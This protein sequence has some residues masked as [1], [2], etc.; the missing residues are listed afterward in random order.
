M[1]YKEENQQIKLDPILIANL[2]GY[3]NKFGDPNCKTCRGLGLVFE[4]D[5]AGRQM[6]SYDL[7][8][9]IRQHCRCQG[10]PPYEFYDGRV[11]G[12]Q[13]C[14]TKKARIAL[15]KIPYLYKMAQIPARFIYK[16]L[17]SFNFNVP[18]SKQDGKDSDQMIEVLD[19]VINTVRD[20]GQQKFRSDQGVYLYGPTGCGKTLLACIILNEIIRLYQKPV[21][22]AKISRDI[23]GKLRASFNPG[24]DFYGEGR[25][26]EEELASVSAL[27]IDD[28]GV[29]RESDWVNLVLYDL[30]DSRYE[31]NL[32]TIITS[33]EPMDS[34]KDI[35]NGRVYS[36]LREM[37]LE[38]QID[39]SD[40][41]LRGKTEI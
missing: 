27:V 31:N 26:I 18:G 3:G 22:F 37:C 40:Y 36:R 41:R 17:Y 33:N 19:N 11:N 24:S 28:F 12:M 35:S 29:H 7:C 32:L 39:A 21:R 16:F 1:L 6:G 13:P 30:I 23:F 2:E 5:T 34:W 4:P 10:V 20:Y 15:E 9:C 25:K 38:T 14:P 8:Q